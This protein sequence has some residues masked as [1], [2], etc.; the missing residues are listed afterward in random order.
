MRHVSL[1][2]LLLLL[3][4]PSDSGGVRL[5]A[6]ATRGFVRLRSATPRVMKLS[7]GSIV[8]GIPALQGGEV[9]ACDGSALGGP[10]SSLPVGRQE[11]RSLRYVPR[12][13]DLKWTVLLS[14]AAAQQMM[15]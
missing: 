1:F 4:L 5:P 9:K 7:R 8:F 2:I 11:R 13:D 10:D 12:I 3:F 14:I 15:K 6:H